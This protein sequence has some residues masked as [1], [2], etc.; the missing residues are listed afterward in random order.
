ML[1]LDMPSLDA[2]NKSD[3]ARRPQIPK[4]WRHAA[5]STEEVQ[6]LLESN[7]PL[8][9]CRAN[10]FRAFELLAPDAVSV[11]LIGQDPYPT[12][13]DA[14]G[15]SFSVPSERKLPR[16]LRNIFVEMQSDIG[17]HPPHGDLTSWARQGVLLANSS[18]T[19]LPGVAG[20]HTAEWSGFTRSWVRFLGDQKQPIVWVLWGN[21][22]QRFR[23]LIGPQHIIIESAHPSPLS[24]R[25][26]F[27]GSRPFSRINDALVS[28][29]KQPINWI[30]HDHE[31][32]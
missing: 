19:T 30:S 12:P 10:I 8:L 15:L 13:G 18:L 32:R 20:A 3:C 2:S 16:S 27:F 5:I 26:G 7:A 24:A 25:R 29:G 28:L 23:D 6:R 1:Q 22:A 11:C 31:N 9:P 14:M 21:H 4:S 17:A